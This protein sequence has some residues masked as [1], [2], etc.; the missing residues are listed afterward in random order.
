MEFRQS[1][2]LLIAACFGVLSGLAEGGVDWVRSVVPD[3]LGWRNDLLPA[4]LWIAPLVNLV[5]FLVLG[6]A[7]A[8]LSRFLR[9]FRDDVLAYAVFGWLATYGPLA[10]LGK[11]HQV[12]CVL[13]ATGVAFQL[14]RY[15]RARKPASRVVL[16]A[17]LGT[18]GALVVLVNLTSAVVASARTTPPGTPGML[19]QSGAPNVL[20]ITLDTLRADHLSAYG[21]QRPSTPNLDR[22]AADGVLFERAFAA[23][24]WTLPSHASIMT[25]RSPAE[26]RAGGSPLDGRYATL[27]EYLAAHG[28]HTAGFVANT[29]YCGA[30][31][32]LARG[33]AVYEDHFGTVGDMVVQTVFGKQLARSLHFVGYYDV[34]G[35]KHAES[36][37]R[38]FLT[39]LATP[40]QGPFFAFLNYFDVHDPYLTAP[41]FDRKF[42]DRPN[43]G[44]RINS[45]LFPRDF[46]GGR[47]LSPQDIQA[48]VDGYDGAL[49]Y[50]DASLGALFREL[51][52]R[53]VLDRT[54]VIVTSDHG[55]SFGNH[56][57]FGHGNSMY[58]DLLHVPLLL[59]YPGH[60]P[61]GR[62][63]SAA[64]SLQAIPATVIQLSGFG[65]SPFPGRSLSTYWNEPL[66]GAGD[67]ADVAFGEFLPGIVPEPTLP[68]GRRG[69]IKSLST[70]QWHLLLHEEGSVELFRDDDT[71]ESKNVAQVPENRQ[72]VHE[73]G[74]RI[75]AF[76]SPHDWELFGRLV[77]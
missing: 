41:P 20:L 34:L 1:R 71:D 64:V 52:A 72:V 31:T 16:A 54:L 48:E 43:R 17:V 47:P 36:V 35:R 6:A 32:G 42:A 67:S 7:V 25:G 28:Y 40:R 60:V 14:C 75:A 57:L 76:V 30:R 62:R 15:A 2:I 63:I 9:R 73:L 53:G 69:A 22:F 3:G 5:L 29:Y 68:L 18:A 21:Y 37:N 46:T 4:I 58:R 10:A 39:W 8:L 24:S 23:A 61:A 74:M 70:S 65:E 13:L 49:A 66:I 59:R 27:A 45:D 55:E 56:G 44:D 38:E 77:Q 12:A 19:A 50:L 51:K 33:F 11:L 26:H